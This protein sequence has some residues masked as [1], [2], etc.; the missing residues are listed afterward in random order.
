MTAFRIRGMAAALAVAAIA[1][2]AAQA[3]EVRVGFVATFT[4]GGAI[5]GNAVRSGWDLA[6]EQLGG[7]LGG[8]PAKVTYGDDQMKPDAA[9]TVIDRML[10]QEKVH[11]I[12]GPIWTNVMLAA[13]DRVL[14]SSAILVSPVSGPS[15]LAGAGCSPYFFAMAWQSDQIPEATAEILNRDKVKD[16]YL[17][18]PNYQAGKDVVRGFERIYKGKVV[19]RSYFQLGLSDFQAEISK[20]RARN[21]VAVAVFAPGGMGIAF[22]KQWATSGLAGKVKLYSMYVIDHTTLPPIGDAALGAEFAYHWNADA[23][24]PATKKFVRAYMAKHNAVPSIYAMQAY[25]AALLIDG[26]VRAV[27]GKVSDRKALAMAMSK[28]PF[29]SARGPFAFNV[30]HFPIQDYFQFSVVKGAN[31]APVIK[32]GRLIYKAYKDPYYK[33][34]KARF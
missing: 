6:I 12:V 9:I 28:A 21:P 34:C 1:A 23:A 19:D 13:K 17:L 24:Y 5:L 27:K 32:T 14:A 7:K 8:Q 31:G 26:G 11:F 15:Q 25:D 20:I 29:H 16:V 18:A 33:E 30:N 2:P 4:G 3:E 22:M 10:T